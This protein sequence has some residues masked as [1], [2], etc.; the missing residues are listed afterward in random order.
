MS[1]F[2]T[3]AMVHFLTYPQCDVPVKEIIAQL[4]KKAG[5]KFGWVLVS[6]EDHEERENDSNVGVHRHAML[7]LNKKINIKDCKWWDIKWE[8]KVYHPHFE[9]AKSK[10][11]CLEYCMK[12]G[13]YEYEGTYKDAP[14]DPNL[15]MEAN[16]KKQ[17][18]NFTFLAKEI[19]K[20]T[21]LDQL[22]EIVPGAVLQHK[23]KVEE[24]I[25]FQNQKK[26]RQKVWPKFFGFKD[27]EDPIWQAVVEWANLNFCKPRQ[28]RQD[29][30]WLWS[31]DPGLGKTYPW[32]ITLKKFFRCYEWRTGDKQGL[33]L[34][35]ADYILMDEL[36]GGI[37]ISELKT[38]AQMYGFNVD[39]KYGEIEDFERNIPLIVTSNRPPGQIYKNCDSSEVNSLV[40][41]FTVLQIDCRQFLEPLE[42]PLPVPEP[43]A[44]LEIIENN[45]QEE[46]DWSLENSDDSVETI[47]M[48]R[49]ALFE[50]QNF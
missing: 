17:S 8:D 38:I 12:D 2:R 35:D 31:Q 41:R 26:L 30:L 18:Y 1:K 23:R 19:K 11:K 47:N 46:E 37:T 5:P 49:K 39:Y 16:G 45:R 3:T 42:E 20:G 40:D 7:E 6:A 29:Q 28:P 9:A 36:K 15:Y 50:N 48:K 21:T 44:P 32:A 43:E 13:N 33:K 4:K 34:K 14:F 27:V 22:D 25:T 24:Y 10:A